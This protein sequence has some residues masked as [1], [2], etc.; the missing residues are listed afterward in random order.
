MIPWLAG[1]GG[2][3]RGQGQSTAAATVCA[4]LERRPW[5]RV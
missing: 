5:M 3:L 4:R 1:P 2:L